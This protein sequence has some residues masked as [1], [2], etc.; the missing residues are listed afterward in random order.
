MI[1][2]PNK[3]NKKWETELKSYGLTKS[4]NEMGLN[5]FT[6]YRALRSGKCTQVT[7]D[8]VNDFLLS[9]RES[10]KKKAHK[11]LSHDQD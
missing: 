4:A 10:N 2:V 7:F 11:V 8:K 3:L 1:D 6:L 5:Y 9:K